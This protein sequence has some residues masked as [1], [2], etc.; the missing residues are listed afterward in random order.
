MLLYVR[1]SCT[2]MG[3]RGCKVSQALCVSVCFY[4]TMHRVRAA[5]V[6]Q[7][8]ADLAAII[9]PV[10]QGSYYSPLYS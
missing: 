8:L 2:V 9:K 5:K 10:D 7:N 3:S 4:A 1:V 6:T